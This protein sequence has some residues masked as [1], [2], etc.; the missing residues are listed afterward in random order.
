MREKRIAV[1]RIDTCRL[2]GTASAVVNTYSAVQDG[3]EFLLTCTV[4]FHGTSI[5]LVGETGTLYVNSDDNLV[6]RQKVALSG[7]CG[8]NTDDEVVSELSCWVL[9]GII[10]S[11][12]KSLSGK[13]EILIAEEA[14]PDVPPVVFIDGE[15]V[16]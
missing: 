9:R 6:H 15:R 7:A 12:T 10:L 16:A 11:E 4:R 1:K 13:V 3:R 2:T 8:L 14:D 5:S